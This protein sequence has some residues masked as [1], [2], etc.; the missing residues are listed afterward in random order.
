MRLGAMRRAAHS[1]SA[2]APCAWRSPRAARTDQ[3][4]TRSRR[5]RIWRPCSCQWL[6]P[7]GRDPCFGGHGAST[8][9]AVV[10]V[11]GLP[12]THAIWRPLRD[13]RPPVGR[14]RAARVRPRRRV[15]GTK[16]ALACSSASC[17]GWRTARRR[18]A[19]PGCADRDARGPTDA[20][21]RSWVVVPTCSTAEPVAGPRSSLVAW[22]RRG[23]IQARSACRPTQ[24]RVRPSRRRLP[25]RD[26]P[27]RGGRLRRR[28]AERLDFTGRACPTRRRT[29]GRTG[30]R[31]D[32]GPVLLPPDPL[33]IEARSLDTRSGWG[34]RRRASAT[35]ITAGWRR[36]RRSWRLSSS[37]SGHPGP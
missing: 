14:R 7:V 22:R 26:R 4:P 32:H 13:D 17:G 3:R 35:C 1:A 16:D 37:G 9:E 15:A 23:M 12:E 5:G 6:Y 11:H 20:P 2:I 27:D 30:G 8:S 19:R 18:G 29:G 24:Y 31:R 33:E 34:P 28:W 36:R 21:V 10:F 25:A